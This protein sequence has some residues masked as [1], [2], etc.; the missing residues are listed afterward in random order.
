MESILTSIKKLLGISEEDDQFDVDVMMH[1]NTVF[2]DLN[3]MGV[4]PSEC[5]YIEDADIIWED[6]VSTKDMEAVKSY[7]Y[8][9]VRLL[10]DPPN[11]SSVLESFNKSIEKLEWR[12]NV[13]AEAKLNKEE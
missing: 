10:F 9:R 3:Q 11:N 7:M 1:I 6:F 5:F 4:G 12:L 13:A 8:M 2:F